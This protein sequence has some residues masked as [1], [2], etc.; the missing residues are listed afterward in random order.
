MR[1]TRRVGMSRRCRTRFLF[2][3]Y[4]IWPIGWLMAMASIGQRPEKSSKRPDKCWPNLATSL[5]GKVGT[6]ALEAKYEAATT[7][8]QK[9]VYS[10]I[11]SNYLV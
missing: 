11:A 3:L 4:S 9:E 6:Q 2:V 5:R 7:C 10:E 8:A 1:F